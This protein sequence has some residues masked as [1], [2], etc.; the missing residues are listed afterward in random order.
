[1]ALGKIEIEK[2]IKEDLEKEF[3]NNYKYCPPFFFK[4]DSKRKCFV[5]IQASNLGHVSVGG[6]KLKLYDIEKITNPIFDNY[7]INYN[8]WSSLMHSTLDW[9]E[10]LSLLCADSIKDLDSS[11]VKIKSYLYEVAIP[12]WEKYQT[13]DNILGLIKSI[14]D[15]SIAFDEEVD[16]NVL[17]IL[18]LTNDELYEIK[19][20][21]FKKNQYD[22]ADYSDEFKNYPKAFQELIDTLENTKDIL[23]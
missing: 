13:L 2:I 14:D 16:F 22:L 19:K 3:G 23:I 17:T 20:N 7:N 4:E 21:E 1:M 11:L 10:N 9:N 6:A 5:N 12:F 8:S 15:L 18:K